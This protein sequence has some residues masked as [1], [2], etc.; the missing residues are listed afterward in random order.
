MFTFLYNSQPIML[1]DCFIS[2][3]SIS[4]QWNGP[5]W[6]FLFR[7]KDKERNWALFGQVWSDMTMSTKVPFAWFNCFE[8]KKLSHL[9]SR[10]DILDDFFLLPTVL[11]WNGKVLLTLFPGRVRNNFDSLHADGLSSKKKWWWWKKCWWW[12]IVFVKWLTKESAL[13]LISS[14]DHFQRL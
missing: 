5:C 8:N 6:F 7:K 14:R 3:I 13:R 12:W 2:F 11:F 4:N 1:R 10:K 9:K